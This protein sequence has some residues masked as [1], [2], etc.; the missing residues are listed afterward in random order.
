MEAGLQGVVCEHGNPCRARLQLCRK[1]IAIRPA[2]DENGDVKGMRVI[3]GHP[4]LIPAALSA[5]SKRKCEPTIL[6]GE[7][8]P[9][10]L[11][12]EISRSYS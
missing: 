2:F 8:S 3:S 4:L 7:P 10:D 9:I 6:D 11:R 12:V 5:V 1:S